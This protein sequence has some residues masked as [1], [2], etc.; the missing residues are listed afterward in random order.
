M[1][2]IAQ[3][4]TVAEI[5]NIY[6]RICRETTAAYKLLERSETILRERI[7]QYGRL[8]RHNSYM[9]FDKETLAKVLEDARRQ[10]WSGVIDK[11]NVRG[12]MDSER[13]KKLDKQL[14]TGE[15]LPQITTEAVLDV[16]HGMIGQLGDFAE[17]VV[18][19]AFELMRRKSDG[20]KSTDQSWKI[21]H[22]VVLGWMCERGYSGKPFRL[23]YRAED[24]A[25]TIENAFR[26]LDGKG[27]IQTHTAEFAGVLNS[28]DTGEG[29]TEY[30][31]FR[32]HKNGNLHMWFK[33]MD[34]VDKMNASAGGARVL[35]AG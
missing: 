26:L 24:D 7:Y 30:F 16:I 2:E 12:M 6:H 14:E 35:K 5:V 4:D 28:S 20:Y 10:T 18:R 23:C 31:R 11:L 19:E 17:S 25:R 21:G 15:G 29:E 32:A 34:L 22:K 9:S 13:R 1:H 27:P 33:R 3:R 8:S